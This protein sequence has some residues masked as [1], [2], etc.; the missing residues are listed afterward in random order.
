MLLLSHACQRVQ[1]R[2]FAERILRQR[3]R[4]V[5]FCGTPVL[6]RMYTYGDCTCIAHPLLLLT[7]DCSNAGRRREGVW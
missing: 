5:F 4:D 2:T 6:L 3:Q 1:D 7:G